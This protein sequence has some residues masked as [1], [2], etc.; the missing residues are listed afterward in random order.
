MSEPTI[1]FKGDRNPDGTAAEFLEG[2]PARH[3][4]SDD[5][6]ALPKELREAVRNSSLYDYAGFKEASAEVKSEATEEKAIPQHASAA[7]TKE[8]K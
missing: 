8:E 6:D 5:Y 3:L 2:V 4:S 1:R 7:R